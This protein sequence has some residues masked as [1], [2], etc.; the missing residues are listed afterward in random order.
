MWKLFCANV[1]WYLQ[2]HQQ[3]KVALDPGLMKIIFSVILCFYERSYNI[4]TILLQ[5]KKGK[6][7]AHAINCV[8]TGAHLPTLGFLSSQETPRRWRWLMPGLQF[9][10]SVEAPGTRLPTWVEWGPLY[11]RTVVR[12]RSN[13][14]YQRTGPPSNTDWFSC[15]RGKPGGTQIFEPGTSRSRIV[16]QEYHIW[17]A[18]PNPA[19]FLKNEKKSCPSTRPNALT[20]IH[21]GSEHVKI[22]F[23]GRLGDWPPLSRAQG[24]VPPILAIDT[25]TSSYPNY[26]ADV[27]RYFVMSDE[28]DGAL[29]NKPLHLEPLLRDNEPPNMVIL[30]NETGVPPD[31]DSHVLSQLGGTT[32]VQMFITILVTHTC[33]WYRRSEST[34]ESSVRNRQHLRGYHLS[35]SVDRWEV[36]ISQH[37]N[38]SKSHHSG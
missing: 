29:S 24:R 22:L 2:Y 11:G 4:D 9:S 19:Y 16:F 27:N 6:L 37:G 23:C 25:E 34:V 14:H 12:A 36:I 1:Y 32:A 28:F 35:D 26:Q 8:A 31:G 38:T 18:I 33:P 17:I 5:G 10:S 21:E 30:K 7:G 20:W 3:L 15:L 13:E